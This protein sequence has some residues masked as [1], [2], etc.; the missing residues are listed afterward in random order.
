MAVSDYISSIVEL[1]KM[2]TC[3]CSSTFSLADTYSDEFGRLDFDRSQLGSGMSNRSKVKR[4]VTAL[5]R[6]AERT[7]KHMFEFQELRQLAKD[8]QIQVNI[9]YITETLSDDAFSVWISFYVC[10]LRSWTLRASSVHSMSRAI[11]WRKGTGHI[12]FKPYESANSYDVYTLVS[13]CCVCFLMQQIL[14][15]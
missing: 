7:N 15:L 4:F 12:S 3:S 14:Y 9:I 8:L 11:F 1:I 2:V 5:N 13:Y 10:F 6:L